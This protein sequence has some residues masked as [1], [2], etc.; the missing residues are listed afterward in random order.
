MTKKEKEALLKAVSEIKVTE[1]NPNPPVF[2]SRTFTSE[3]TS[4]RYEIKHDNSSVYGSIFSDSII[5]DGNVIHRVIIKMD[6]YNNVGANAEI[7]CYNKA[8]NEQKILQIATL[9]YQLLD[10]QAE[11]KES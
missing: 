8:F 2:E 6:S 4:N 7:Y 9:I 3:I 5:D 10:E 1:N 11:R